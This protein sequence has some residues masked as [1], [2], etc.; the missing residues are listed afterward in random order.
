MIRLRDRCVILTATSGVQD[1]LGGD[2]ISWEDADE[3]M[4]PCVIQP[5]NTSE[6]AYSSDDVT[7]R[8]RARFL[9]STTLSAEK[10]VRWRGLELE[11]DGEVQLVV[12]KN[13]RPHHNETVLEL[14]RTID[15]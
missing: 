11:V 8:W 9:P 1:E 2:S 13:G 3:L 6:Y 12:D 15:S 10:R 5:L 7:S 4:E 14:V